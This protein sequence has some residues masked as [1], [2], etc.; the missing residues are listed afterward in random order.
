MNMSDDYDFGF[1]MVDEDDLEVSTATQQPVQAE[2]PSDQIDAIMDKLEQ[3]DARILSSDNSGAVNEHRALV[4]Q[5]VAVKLR[6]VEDLI[7]P[8]L[9]NLK[10]NPEKDIIRWPNRAVIIDKQ[11]EKIKALTRYFDK[12]E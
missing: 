8:L 9:L 2:I 4:E 11:I 6:D 10:K 3:L 7:L 12:F 1:T 5:D